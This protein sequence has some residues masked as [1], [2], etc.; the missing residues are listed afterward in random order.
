MCGCDMVGGVKIIQCLEA[1]MELTAQQAAEMRAK[2][3]ALMTVVALQHTYYAAMFD[4][5]WG[6]PA[7]WRVLFHNTLDA[8]VMM[9]GQPSEDV[10]TFAHDAWMHLNKV[11][12]DQL[13][14][15]AADAKPVVVNILVSSDMPQRAIGEAIARQINELAPD[16]EYVINVDMTGE[17]PGT[18]E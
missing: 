4:L 9:P 3:T 10:R 8:Y 15:A 2:S 14:P 5:Q 18:G 17:Q 11:F 12:F 13:A 6:N 16:R 1:K 7:N